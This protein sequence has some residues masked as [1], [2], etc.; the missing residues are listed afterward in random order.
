MSR[1]FVVA[2][3]AFCLCC[4]GCGGAGSSW[5]EGK[6]VAE[7]MDTKVEWEFRS[8]GEL[9]TRSLGGRW[10]GGEIEEEQTATKGRTWS[11]EG[12]V[13][14]MVGLD[15]KTQLGTVTRTDYGFIVAFAGAPFPVAFERP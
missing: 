8:N 14:S 3:V 5:I 7:V 13:L 11:L 1:M 10:F 2:C 12:D 6:W 9:W 15:G 4:V